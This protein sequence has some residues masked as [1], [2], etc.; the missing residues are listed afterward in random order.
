MLGS[1]I[2][3][4]FKPFSIEHGLKEI[5]KKEKT[6]ELKREIGAL[7]NLS[8]Y[9]LEKKI[10]EREIELEDSARD[11]IKKI[12]GVL[13]GRLNPLARNL[14][15]SN[16]NLVGLAELTYR[17]MKIGNGEPYVPI[18]RP[19]MN[20]QQ[21]KTL[22]GRLGPNHK[23][24]DR[25]K[26]YGVDDSLKKRIKKYGLVA[27]GIAG[28]TIGGVALHGYLTHQ[29]HFSNLAHNPLLNPYIV[30][31]QLRTVPYV[32]PIISSVVSGEQP[33]AVEGK[34]KNPGK[35]R[36][37]KYLACGA[38]LFA[39]GAGLALDLDGDNVIGFN[40]ITKYHTNSIKRNP[41]LEYA[42]NHGVKN[43]TL[44]SYVIPLESD[45]KLDAN[46]KALIDA[47]GNIDSALIPKEIRDNY[48]TTEEINSVQENLLKNALANGKISDTEVDALKHL[49][50]WDRWW[51]VRDIYSSG[52]IDDAK[53]QENWDGDKTTNGSP[54]SNYEEIMQG[55]N[56]LESLE[57]NP[58]NPSERYVVMVNVFGG[59][60][61]LERSREI[62]EK[63][64]KNG[65][66]DD[67]IYLAL[68]PGE[69]GVSDF[70]ATIDHIG[71]AGQRSTADYFLN[72]IKNLPSDEN[73][74]VLVCSTSHGNDDRI[75]IGGNVFLP[76]LNKAL[77]EMKYGKAITVIDCC[78]AGGFVAGLNNNPYE[79]ANMLGISQQS[80]YETSSIPFMKVFVEYLDS[81]LN[82]EGAFNQASYD[83]IELYDHHPGIYFGSPEEFTNPLKYVKPEN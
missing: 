39:L 43:P 79:L 3:N 80:K 59:G 63:L 72:S 41:A 13:E 8:E 26:D 46:E 81:G 62:C 24:K 33:I 42:V 23:D 27:A 31:N 40:E 48:Y 4:L 44:A 70:P 71:N 37:W 30:T 77:Y 29:N 56:P 20:G 21:L 73:D 18:T 19:V 52:M 60:F 9:Q 6:R 15:Y 11:E 65:C 74:I 45:G 2:G 55:T 51:I 16:P 76:E 35:K 25:N 78:K 36:R 67:Q 53:L 28:V 5:K 34:I 54:L 68:N 47:V 49:E 1:H 64:I 10:R 61:E 58:S 69:D 82:V 14:I 75:T 57:T 17:N 38:A 22:L 7:K 83:M 66:K 12:E 50:T 32:L